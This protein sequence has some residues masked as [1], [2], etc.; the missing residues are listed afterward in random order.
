MTTATLTPEQFAEQ[1]LAKFDDRI[2]TLQAENRTE[3]AKTLAEFRDEHNRKAASAMVPGLQI[4]GKEVKD[5]SFSRFIK[6]A[7]E[8]IRRGDVAMKEICPLEFEMHEAAYKVQKDLAGNVDTAGGYMVPAQVMA[9]KIIPLL[10][11]RLVLDRLGVTHLEG[12]VGSPVQIP[13]VTGGTTGYWVNHNTQSDPTAV[14][15]SEPTFGQVEMSPKTA[16]AAC[17]MANSFLNQSMVAADMFVQKQIARDIG[18]LIETA[19]FN[20]SGSSGQPRGIL[21]ETGIGTVTSVG[22]V[23]AGTFFNKSTDYIVTLRKARKDL[24]P[25]VK[26]VMNPDIWGSL[27]NTVDATNQPQGRRLITDKPDTLLR[28]F[29]YVVTGNV[30]DN[31]LILGDWAD[32]VIGHWGGLV[33]KVDDLSMLRLLQTQILVSTEVDTLALEPKSFVNGTGVTV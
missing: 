7:R 23:A 17:R 29:E 31:T 8:A 3:V 33:V 10:Q 1:A 30:P 32:L 16:A 15:K 27:L 21:Q 2:K 11:E 9:A 26:W 14:T 22:S 13:K 12:L 18:L 19:A 4:N 25:N 5:F 20:G 24:P 6:G 28:G